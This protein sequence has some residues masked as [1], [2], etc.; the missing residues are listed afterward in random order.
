M[1]NPLSHSAQDFRMSLHF[2][3]SKSFC[4]KFFCLVGAWLTTSGCSSFNS[5]WKKAAQ[6][7][8]PTGEIEGRWQGSWLS[9]ANHHTGALRCI[10]C[11]QQ[12]GTYKARFHAKYEKVLSFG[13]TVNLSVK[14]AEGGQQK[15]EG[16]ANLAWWAGGV[17]HYEG[18]ASATNFFSTYS[19]KYDHGTFQMK[20]P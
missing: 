7:P 13:Y 19:C 1:V 15:F 2:S 3:V 14:P 10:V 4:L 6:N 9:D 16:E 18:Q 5:E 8:V 17:Y 20:R 12:E 11:K